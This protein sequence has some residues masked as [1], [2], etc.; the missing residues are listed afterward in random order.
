MN[1]RL[2][3]ILVPV[4]SIRSENDLGIGDVSSLHEFVNF[5]AETGFGFVQ[6]LPVNETGPDNSPYNAI[7]SVAIEPMTLDC[8]THG[9]KDLTKE[10]FEEVLASYDMD[11][12]RSGAVKYAEVSRLKHDLLR[13]SYGRFCETVLNK[14][15]TRAEAFDAFRRDEA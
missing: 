10:A 9:L 14:V 5:A 2:A 11:S 1:C 6:L 3:G 12:L 8:S 13:R 7:S 4:F 15:D